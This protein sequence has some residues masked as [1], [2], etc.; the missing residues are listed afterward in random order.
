MATTP[1]F[2]ATGSKS[3]IQG[4]SAD[5]AYPATVD[6]DDMLVISVTNTSNLPNTPSGWTFIGQAGGGNPYTTTAFCKVADGTETGTQTITIDGAN[7]WIFC[8]MTS[9]SG[10]DPDS[11]PL[12]TDLNTY[13]SKTGTTVDLRDVTNNTDKGQI[14]VNVGFENTGT[15]GYSNYTKHF[16]NTNWGS[17][18]SVDANSGLNSGDT[19]TQPSDYLYFIEW[20]FT[21]LE[22]SPTFVTIDKINDL[23]LSTNLTMK[24]IR[25]I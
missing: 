4:T 22:G 5:V 8:E 16:A 15:S 19:I 12:F 13:A 17:S 20:I 3:D 10:V 21:G 6:A 25:D 2:K 23:S 14:A 24:K 1:S 11:S 18:M 7:N 9:Y